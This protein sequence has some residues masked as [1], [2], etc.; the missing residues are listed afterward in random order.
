MSKFAD[1]LAVDVVKG[2]PSLQDRMQ[3]TVAPETIDGVRVHVITPKTIP[4]ENQDKVLIHT[5][6]GCYVLFPGE[7]VPP[8]GS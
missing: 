7:S 5:H 4:P 1:A 6:G 2:I 8:R 3:V